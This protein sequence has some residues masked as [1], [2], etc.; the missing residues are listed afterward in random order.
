MDMYNVISNGII[1]DNEA[2]VT[3]SVD[4]L[5]S[6]LFFINGRDINII[7][8]VKNNGSLDGTVFVAAEKVENISF[9][10]GDRIEFKINGQYLEFV[11]EDITLVTVDENTVK[12][13]MKTPHDPESDSSIFSIALKV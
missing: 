12:F 9:S 1:Y 5:I 6:K 3:I 2:N 7:K 13:Y 11:I 8:Y 4:Q 10:N